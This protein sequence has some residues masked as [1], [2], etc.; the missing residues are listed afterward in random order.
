VGAVRLSPGL[1][2]SRRDVERAIAVMA[3]FAA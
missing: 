1:A 3:S 2:T